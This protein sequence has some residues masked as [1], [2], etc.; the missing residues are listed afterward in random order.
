MVNLQKVNFVAAI[1]HEIKS[2]YLKTHIIREIVR[3]GHAILVLKVW[4]TR[5][6]CFYY[7]VFDVSPIFVRGHSQSFQSLEKLG[8]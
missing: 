8:H 2:Q 1:Y 7:D 3:L 4:L 5:N 6:Q